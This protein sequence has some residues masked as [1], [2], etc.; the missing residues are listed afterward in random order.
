MVR[1]AHWAVIIRADRWATERL[2]H[3]DTLT[4]PSHPTG[5]VLPAKAGPVTSS[6]PGAVGSSSAGALGS[7]SPGGVGSSSARSVGPPSARSVG[8]APARPSEGDDVLLVAD[9]VLVGLGRVAAADPSALEIK[10]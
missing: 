6:S 2:F 9:D 1:M 5:P 3:H 8:S 7:S 4:V 10:Y